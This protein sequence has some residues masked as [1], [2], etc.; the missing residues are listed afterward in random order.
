MGRSGIYSVLVCAT[1]GRGVTPLGKPRRPGSGWRPVV[2]DVQRLV[3]AVFTGE[4]GAQG[5]DSQTAGT[6][7]AVADYIAAQL[8]VL[9]MLDPGARLGRPESAHK[10]RAAAR[11]IRSVLGTYAKLFKKSAVKELREELKWFADAVDQPLRDVDAVQ[12]QF[13]PSAQSLSPLSGG[14]LPF[15]KDEAMLGRAY[16]AAYRRAHET[17]KSERYYQL[18]SDLR[19]FYLAPPMK[20][21]DASKGKHASRKGSALPDA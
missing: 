1:S 7:K 17:L 11:R 12:K 15:N 8:D 19:S 13:P 2:S 20:G 3:N 10:M 18:I 9:L 4:S 21:R 14:T 16:D 6:V 5:G